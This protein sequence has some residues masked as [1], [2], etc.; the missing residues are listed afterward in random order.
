VGNT[1]TIADLSMVGYL[2]FPKSETGLDL[3]V[4]HPGVA[5][6]LGRIAAIPG[7]RAPYDL[8]QGQRM[9]TYF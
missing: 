3:A 6:W 5:A 7:W 8:L 1:P 4:S 9:K 2:F